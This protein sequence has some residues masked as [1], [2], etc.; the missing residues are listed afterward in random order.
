KSYKALSYAWGDST[1]TKGIIINNCKSRVLASLHSAL[2]NLHIGVL[3]GKEE[4]TYIWADAICINQKDNDEKTHEVQQM[5]RI[6]EN[7]TEVIVWL[8]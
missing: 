5:K 3:A 4:S 6:Y 1:M 2:F 7:A 8:G